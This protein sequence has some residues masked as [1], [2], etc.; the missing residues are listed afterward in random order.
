MML[1]SLPPAS[2]PPLLEVLALQTPPLSLRR[3]LPDP[4]H[5][6]QL[7]DHRPP[8]LTAAPPPLLHL[9]HHPGRSP[10]RCHPDG[11][12]QAEKQ[13][14]VRLLVQALQLRRL[15]RAPASP[16]LLPSHLAPWRRLQLLP[17]AKEELSPAPCPS[18]VELLRGST[19]LPCHRSPTHCHRNRL[20]PQMLWRAVA[21]ELKQ[22]V[23][24]EPLRPLLES[25]T[26]R[27]PPPVLQGLLL[28]HRLPPARQ[29]PTRCLRSWCRERLLLVAVAEPQQSRPQLRSLGQLSALL[30]QHP[31]PRTP[32]RPTQLLGHPPPASRLGERR[33]L[34]EL[35]AEGEELRSAQP[36]PPPPLTA[37]HPL[38]PLPCR[39]PMRC[40]RSR[41]QQLPKPQVAPQLRP[42]RRL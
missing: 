39:N 37:A 29:S 41:R 23:A 36:P 10:R 17:S 7:P 34:Q 40:R 8:E 6:V 5:Q 20:P 24:R 25:Q 38:L 18:S 21:L 35:E 28:R 4:A 12:Q 9:G 32:A 16:A 11:Y 22:L 42:P 26:R 13:P 3:D 19:P 1:W 31:L 2:R 14:P 33:P 15:L 27:A 30:P